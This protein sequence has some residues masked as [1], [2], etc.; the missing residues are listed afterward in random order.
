MP[1]KQS[2]FGA[3]PVRR[4]ARQAAARASKSLEETRL[5][6]TYCTSSQSRH[7]AS[8]SWLFFLGLLGQCDSKVTRIG[9]DYS[10][11]KYLSSPQALRRDLVARPMPYISSEA[12]RAS[13]HQC[14]GS[15]RGACASPRPVDHPEAPRSC[16]CGPLRE[17]FGL[18]F[19]PKTS[20]NMAEAAVSSS[21]HPL[22][23]TFGALDP[24]AGLQLILFRHRKGDHL[25]AP[26][27]QASLAPPTGSHRPGPAPSGCC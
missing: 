20:Q 25:S 15:S 26:L 24:L 4:A 6:V 2:P 22:T 27:L 5:Q 10:M 1:L 3:R 12:P 13:L 8:K 16:I 7:K 19:A 23:S 9:Y 11:L 17:L 18:Y 21:T 14:W